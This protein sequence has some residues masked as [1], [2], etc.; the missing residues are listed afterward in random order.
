MRA[1]GS[2]LRV[3]VVVAVAFASYTADG[4][5]SSTQTAALP[6]ATKPDGASAPL[7]RSADLTYQ[8]AFRVPEGTFGGSSF[9]YG[10]TA[11]TFNPEH[12]SLFIVGHDWHQQVAE[13]SIP[14]IRTAARIDELA[15]ARVLQPF[16]DATEGKLS[17]VGPNNVKVGGLLVY[18][19]Q[20]YLTAFL[21]YD[22][23]GVQTL[24][25]FVSGLD[26]KVQGDA[27]GPFEVGK[28]RAGFVSGYFGLV[29]HQWREALGGPVLNG[30]CCLGVISRT[31]YGPAL[32]TIDPLDVGAK[33]PVPANPLV[34]YTAMRPL[35]EPKTT[36][37]G[38]GN[39]S[40]LFNGTT[41]VRGVVFPDNTRSALFFGRQ[42]LGPFCYGP[43]TS[44]QS[45]GGQLADGGVDRF[46]YD[47][48][49]GNKGTHGYPYAYYV[50]AYDALDLAAVKSR[51]R[52]PWTIRPY[53]TW[54][55]EIPFV[56]ANAR[57]N[58]AAY[59]AQTGRIFVSQAYGD[60]ER[61][62]IHVF[63][64]HAVAA[65]Q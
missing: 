2:S 53:A 21:Y 41:E 3:L 12:E 51:K 44:D 57:V 35:L 11:L 48:G 56:N 7:I 54:K 50:W 64:V 52:E 49:D 20:L 31:S 26:L 6:A 15:Y 60:G 46:C 1:P 45:L 19:S 63:A 28:L 18:Q 25:H 29:P 43:G 9:A 32:F 42:G 39:T 24:S 34:Y 61:P 23:A 10:G 40:T 55:L 38:W 5:G 36:G 22:G 65:A 37:D 30:N 59:D 4:R 16:A 17:L 13:I 33:N 62:L 58:G 14:P 27:R 47:P 8:G